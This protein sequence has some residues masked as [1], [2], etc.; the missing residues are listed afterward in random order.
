MDQFDVVDI[1]ELNSNAFFHYT[2]VNNLSSISEKG[3]EPKIG[4]NAVGI[5]TTEKIFFTIGEKN[6]LVLMDSWIRWLIA[7]SAADF[8]GEKMDKPMYAL[9]TFLLKAKLF[10]RFLLT[11]FVKWELNRKYKKVNAFKKLKAILDESVYL[12]LD[13]EMDVDYSFEDIDEV[14]KG[15]FDRELLKLMYQK[16]SDVNDTY[17][18]YWNMHTISRKT[19]AKE[20]IHIVKVDN[21]I[22]A[23]DILKYM[24]KNAAIKIKRELPYLYEY[25]KWCER[26]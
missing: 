1:R 18:E 11:L 7:K 20:K 6:S 8:P 3:L 22:K 17:M 2:N 14:K 25:F 5:E 10:P 12:V 24:R 15:N 13:L 21:S 26:N 4:E 19:I 16:Y 9:A 23:S